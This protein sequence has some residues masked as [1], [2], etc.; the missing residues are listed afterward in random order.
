VA[1]F[2]EIARRVSWMVMMFTGHFALTLFVAVAM[3]VEIAG[4]MPR[5]VVM[6]ASFFFGHFQ[7]PSV[8]QRA[9]RPM[10]PE[11]WPATCRRL[12][13]T[14]PPYPTPIRSNVSGSDE[15]K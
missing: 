7:S 8:L 2:V 5:M 14:R 6:L 9:R 1:L 13:L 15:R 3:L 4:L 10:A 12:S 11:G